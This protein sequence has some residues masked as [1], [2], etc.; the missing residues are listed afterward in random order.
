MLSRRP[1]DARMW[2]LY[3]EHLLI[4]N[5]L[6]ERLRRAADLVL[7]ADAI[8]TGHRSGGLLVRHQASRAAQAGGERARYRR[9]PGSAKARKVRRT[10]R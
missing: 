6:A 10:G 9:G 8:N 5:D 3:I 4:L 7:A 1:V 2:S